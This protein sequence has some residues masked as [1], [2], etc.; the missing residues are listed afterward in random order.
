MRRKLENDK[1]KKRITISLDK[2]IDKFLDE[3]TANKS[4]LIEWLL[5]EY[6]NT[7]GIDTKKI[8]I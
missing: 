1:K 3:N 6:L 5:Y 7:I 4:K 2:D 8:I